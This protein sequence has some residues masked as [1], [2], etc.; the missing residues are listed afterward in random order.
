MNAWFGRRPP[1]ICL[2]GECCIGDGEGQHRLVYRK[3]WALLA[4]LAIERP[5]VHRR[6]QL[7]AMLWPDLNHQAALTNLR[8]VL[9]D[10]NRVLKKT[11]GEG[12]LLVERETVSLCPDASYGLLDVDLLESNAAAT[13]TGMARLSQHWLASAGELLEGLVPE[14]CEDFCEWLSGTRGWLRQRLLN[15]LECA[16]REAT[17]AGNP[18]LA[19]LLLRRHVALDPWDEVQ[20]RA[21]MRLYLDMGE[22]RLALNCYR[23]LERSLRQELDVEPQAATRALVAQMGVREQPAAPAYRRMWALPEALNA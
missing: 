1:L 7:A 14:S 12:V 19:V 10:L 13:A 4:Y 5:R 18:E 23:A 9:A 20:Q 17:E 15:A 8:Q 11:V 2:L 16:S 21:L 22:P 6:S 3:G